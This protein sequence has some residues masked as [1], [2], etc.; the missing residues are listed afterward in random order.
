M[1][2][3]PRQ[4]LPMQLLPRWTG[5]PIR[6][7]LRIGH[8]ASL[9]LLVYVALRSSSYPRVLA[10]VERA[11]RLLPAKAKDDFRGALAR[12]E[13]VE[14]VAHRIFP[15]HP[16]LPQALTVC[17]Q[18]WRRSLPARIHLGAMR[19]NAGAL[20]AHA[21]VE[22]NGEVIVGATERLAEYELFSGIEAAE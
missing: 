1:P 20:S 2:E 14:R 22:S 9:L 16:C 8:T 4:F 10:G 5:R 19:D 12:A 18:Y 15:G 13:R 11:A 3:L 6:E 7:Q 17:F 21:W